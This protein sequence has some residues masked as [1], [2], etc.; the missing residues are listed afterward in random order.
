MCPATELVTQQLVSHARPAACSSPLLAACF[1]PLPVCVI[2]AHSNPYSLAFPVLQVAYWLTKLAAV[3]S[4]ASRP[5]SRKGA[6][7]C[8]HGQLGWRS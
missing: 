7:T 6:R 8:S 4:V 2:S 1:C 5:G 3:T